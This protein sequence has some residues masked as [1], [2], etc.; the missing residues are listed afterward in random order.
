LENV[1]RY[2]LNEI[3]DFISMHFAGARQSFQNQ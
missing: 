3:G 1:I 2:P